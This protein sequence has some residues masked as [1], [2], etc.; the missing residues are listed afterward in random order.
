VAISASEQV[1][2]ELRK[3]LR[4]EAQFQPKVRKL[5]KRMI[6]AHMESVRR[7][8]EPLLANRFKTLWAELLFEHYNNVQRAFGGSVRKF[9]EKGLTFW[10]LKQFLE[11]DEQIT[12]ERDLEILAAALLLWAQKQAPIQ[13][14]FI[15]ETNA[16]NIREAMEEA[17]QALLETGEDINNINTSR[18]SG[19]ILQRKMNSRVPSII[20]TET[21]SPSESTKLMEAASLSGMDPRSVAVGAALPVVTATKQWN[22]VGDLKVRPIHQAANKQVRKMS[23]AFDVGGEKLMHPGDSSLGATAKNTANCRCAALYR[24]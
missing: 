14:R 3:K 10:Y 15:T 5:F 23:A 6:S 16:I 19:V 4:L 18:V 12:D 7:T 17:R 2:N 9:Q 11:V 1:T 8:G 20:M 24:L 21:Q 13:G 22:T